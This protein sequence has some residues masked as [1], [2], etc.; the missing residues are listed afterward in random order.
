[1]AESDPVIARIASGVAAVPADAWDSLA[2]GDDPFL[3]HAF[4][5]L[6]EE[7]G[8]VGPGT[9][10]QSAPVCIDGPDGRLAAAAPAYLKAHSQGEYVFDHGWAD[11]WR[12]AGGD[13]YPKL[14]VAVPFTPVPGRRLLTRDAAHVPALIGALEAVVTQNGLSSAHATFVTED[15]LDAFRAAGWLIRR[16]SQFHWFDRG[17]GD[18]DGF[19]AALSSRKRKDL[20]KERATAQAAVRI[21]ALTGDAIRPEHWDVMWACYQD[22]GARKWGTPYWTREAFALL[23]ERMADR[24]LLV[25]AH[26]RDTG[27]P[28]AAA[29]NLIGTDAL[30]GRYWGCLADIPCLHFELCYYQAIDF[31]LARGLGRVEAGAQ[32]QHKLARG[33]EP[34][35]TW[36]AHFIP[37]P[38]FRAAVADFLEREIA[39]V[40]QESQWLAGHAPFRRGDG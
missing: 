10:W 36:S 12:R 6:L 4:L 24:V 19:L 17:Y 8:S 23:G 15:Q 14:Q 35:P 39:A 22:T 18:F 27:R 40:E 20:R 11:A 13:Y 37:H 30:Y 7:S 9:G 2:G 25:V 5:T 32:G 16:D 3:S 26:E 1:M 29:L 38:G 21:E 28:V 31:A 34:V 33:Y